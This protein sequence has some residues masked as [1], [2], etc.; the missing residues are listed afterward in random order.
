MTSPTSQVT[1]FSRDV[2]GRFM[3]NGLDEA[4]RSTDTA[5][6]PD[7]RPF[8]VIVIGGGTFGP[9]V[10]QHLFSIDSAHRHRVLVLEGGPLVLS[11]HVQNYPMLGLG[12]PG[13]TS[14]ADLRAAGQA[15]RPR[16]EVWGLAWHSDTPFPGLAYCVGGRSL[17]FGGWSPQLLPEE[18]PPDDWP[19]GLRSDLGDR[20]FREASRQIGID[21]TNDFIYGP[22][23][24]ALRERIFDGIAAGQVA[25][26]VSLAAL[27]DHPA[28]PTDTVPKRA[29]LL[30]LLGLADSKR[31]ED[32]LRKLLKLEAPLAVQ[33]RTRPGFFPFNKFSAV[34]LLIKAVRTAWAESN[35]D[36]VKKRLMMVPHCHVKRLV[37]AS[38]RVVAVE[39]NQGVMPVPS[40]G[41]VVVATGTIEST[42]LA[43][44]SF[45][46]TPNYGLIGR[47]FLAHLR[48]NLT[49]RFRRD[50]LP[51][52]PALK[53]L[54]ASALFVKGRHATS[55]SVGHFH[56][57]ITA[58][59]LGPIGANS[60]AELFKKV[61]D[62]DTFDRFRTASDT[63]VVVTI[64]GVGEMEP[65][66]PDS[67]ISL[68]PEAD[69]Y[70]ARRAFVRLRPSTRDLEQWQAMDQTADDLALVL[71][72][73]QGYEVLTP[74]GFVAVMAGHAASEVLDFPNRRDGLGT[75]HHEAGTLWMGD[76]PAT[77]VTTPDG[78]FH[79]VANAYAAGPAVFP[80][81]GSPNPM[82]TG[83]ALAR[84]LAEHLSPLPQPLSP[85]D[86]F[87]LLFNGYDTSG[88]R[89]AGRGDFIVVDGTLEAVPG[90][91]IGLSWCTT[92]MPA[93]YTLR[94]EWLR[95][96]HDDNSGV[97]VRF[98]NPDSKGYNNTAYVAVHFGFE[99][100]IDELAR[101][102]GLDI[103]RTGA[104]Y[105]E[106]DQTAT[107]RAAR[108]PGEW[109]DFEIRVQGQEYT[110]LLNGEQVTQFQNPHA[111]RGL[112][113][114]PDSPSFV[115]L[116]AHT[117]RVAFRN[118]R[119]RADT[120]R[121]KKKKKKLLS[122][123]CG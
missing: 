43:L 18:M 37:T 24:T 44:L 122:R 11:E 102:N 78:R 20:Y 33:S 106:P 98:P 31:S 68:D 58:A 84:R 92:P 82:L 56:L 39:T 30:D 91:D 7:A 32:D 105:N 101:P 21:E 41:V 87:Q 114:A 104:I 4:L 27:P 8:D 66:N 113:S 52:D 79:H 13:A 35:G 3:C 108:P 119:F 96:R 86:G 48:S 22:L 40:S 72:N 61:P 112:P 1:D 62:I 57:Q 77:S 5:A 53:E 9:V 12:V 107:P 73:G 117:G 94:L 100:Q 80:T 54:Q 38:G 97:F 45:E 70:V 64:R 23:H 75:T 83:V 19:V 17:Y 55:G 2:I 123:I 99:V 110:V 76:N 67:F 115:G 85:S 59:G 118:I 121:T 26:V 47:N 29:E 36:D 88:W 65:Q 60:E 69:E 15:D 28:V 81:T 49:V 120:A 103:H 93:D 71:A 42:R 6:R 46:G 111:G 16:Q 89:M 63:D 95:W 14:I 74:A 34:P 25:N 109:N 90:D 50:V 116:Q 10:A 51:I